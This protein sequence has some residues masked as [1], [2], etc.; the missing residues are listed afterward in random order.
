MLVPDLALA[1]ATPLFLAA[2]RALAVAGQAAA[3][4]LYSI[5]VLVVTVDTARHRRLALV[6]GTATFAA[7]MALAGAG[8]SGDPRALALSAGAT[9]LCYCGWTLAM[10]HALRAR[11]G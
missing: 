2:E 1:G 5:A 3:N 11:P 6:L 7:G 9:I 8:F 4:G 10:S